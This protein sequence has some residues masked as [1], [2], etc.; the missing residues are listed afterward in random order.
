MSRKAKILVTSAAGKTGLPLVQQL[1]ERGFPVRAMVRREDA[2]ARVMR[3]MGAEVMVGNIFDMADVQ[4]AMAGVQRAYHCAPTAP[5]G[6]QFGAIFAAA[7][8]EARLEHVVMLGQW[9][10]DVRHVS[11]FTRDVWLSE[12]MLKL[13]PDTTLSVVNVGWFADNYFM[14]LPMAAQLGVLPMPLGDGDEKKNAGPSNEAIAAVAAGCLADPAIHAGKTYRPTGPE[15]LS[16]NEIAAAMGTALGRRVRYMPVSDRMF[17]KAVRA[18]A[19]SNYSHLMLSQL[20]IYVQEYRRRAFAVNAPTDVVETVGGMAPEAFLETAWRAATRPEAQRTVSK[21][22]AALWGFA[23]VGLTP[24]PDLERAMA[25]AHLPVLE[26]PRYV[27]DST[28][29]VETHSG[30]LTAAA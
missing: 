22:L 19:P 16:P 20:A 26:N 29:W 27:G 3:D 23:R 1:C 18:S 8:A 11:S 5:G 9:L 21:K 6:L 7:A 4:R 12:E 14:V 10:S 15:L 24:V 13:L 2:R 25:E 28:D 17:A 30:S